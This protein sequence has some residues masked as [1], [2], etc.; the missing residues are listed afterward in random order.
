M[1]GKGIATEASGERKEHSR[2]ERA[3][4][5]HSCIS[6]QGQSEENLWAPRNQM[7]TRLHLPNTEGALTTHTGSIQTILSPGIQTP[8]PPLLP[9][10]T[11]MLFFP[12]SLA[13]R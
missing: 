1:E 11:V 12:A 3:V 13:K 4:D 8:C 6:A 2:P 9:G 10:H 5:E 7:A